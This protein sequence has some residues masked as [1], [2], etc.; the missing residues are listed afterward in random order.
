MRI[1]GATDSTYV[2]LLTHMGLVTRQFRFW[3]SQGLSGRAPY[4][5]AQALHRP[6][7]YGDLGVLAGFAQRAG[8]SL[9]APH[10]LT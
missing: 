6:L 9:H 1:L 5:A 7:A 8:R 3:V 2:G 10:P 4:L